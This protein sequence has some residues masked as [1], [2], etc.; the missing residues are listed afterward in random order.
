MLGNAVHENITKLSVNWFE[1]IKLIPITIL[2][3]C[4]YL[5]ITFITEHRQQKVTEHRQQKVTE[6]RQQ[7]V[8]EHRQQKAMHNCMHRYPLRRGNDFL[9][10]I[11]F[12][13]LNFYNLIEG[14]I[15]YNNLLRYSWCLTIK[16]NCQR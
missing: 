16:V 5:V 4:S 14:R 8:T 15:L 11:K 9:E 2:E 12:F 10:F 6:H 7:K 1:I 3:D 13:N